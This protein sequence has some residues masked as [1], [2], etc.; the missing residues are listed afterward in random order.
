MRR[1]KK[2]AHLHRL[3]FWLR[4]GDDLSS[5][6]P[7][8]RHKVPASARTFPGWLN[9]IGSIPVF[10]PMSI[11]PDVPPVGVLPMAINPNSIPPRTCRPDN[12]SGS[13][14]R[15]T[16]AEMNVDPGVTVGNKK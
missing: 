8:T 7:V 3:P 9:V 5:F 1:K 15:W 13:D 16:D 12:N 11:D 2:G 4:S 6:H 14:S 10:D